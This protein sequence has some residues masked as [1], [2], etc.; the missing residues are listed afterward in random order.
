MTSQPLQHLDDWEDFVASR[1]REGKGEEEFRN[2]SAD[3]NPG[4]P[5]F[6]GRITRTRQWTSYAPSGRMFL[7]LRRGKKSIWEAAEYLNT[8]VTSPRPRTFYRLPKRSAGTGIRAGSCWPV[9]FMIWAKCYA[10]M[11]SRN[12]RWWAIRFR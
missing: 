5:N 6:T 1:Y 9:W 2:Y 10:C 8:L 4:W 12:G 11:A 7:T 3:A